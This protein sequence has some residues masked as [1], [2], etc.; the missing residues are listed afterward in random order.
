MYILHT[1][2]LTGTHTHTHTHITYMC[3]TYVYESCRDMS[4]INFNIYMKDSEQ[5][6]ILLW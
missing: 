6:L 2:R 5:S 1:L 3:N 4:K